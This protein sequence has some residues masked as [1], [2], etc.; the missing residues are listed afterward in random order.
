MVYWCGLCYTDFAS[1][2]SLKRHLDCKKHLDREQAYL[3]RKESEDIKDARDV[4]IEESEEQ[5]MH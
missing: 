5:K 3:A 1:S 4:L 2:F